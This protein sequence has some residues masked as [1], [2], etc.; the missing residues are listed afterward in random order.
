[1]SRCCLCALRVILLFYRITRLWLTLSPVY[2]TQY[3]STSKT[4]QCPASIAPCQLIATNCLLLRCQY[5]FLQ[6]A[7]TALRDHSLLVTKLTRIRCV[8]VRIR[9]DCPCTDWPLLE[10]LADVSSHTAASGYSWAWLPVRRHAATH[11]TRSAASPLMTPKTNH[12]CRFLLLSSSHPQQPACRH[13]V[14]DCGSS[15]SYT[16]F[17]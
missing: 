12:W 5:F 17:F 10:S 8:D 13:S 3:C 7:C 11:P 2:G 6:T 14:C 9:T 16:Y 1:M 4:V 15:D